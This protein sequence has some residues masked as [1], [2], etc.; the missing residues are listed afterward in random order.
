MVEE[1]YDDAECRGHSDLFFPSDDKP[2]KPAKY[3]IVEA[4]RYCSRCPVLNNCR[5][6][7]QKYPQDYIDI[8]N[9]VVAGCF[10]AEFRR[11]WR[12]SSERGKKGFRGL[13]YGQMKDYEPLTS[14]LNWMWETSANKDND[15]TSWL[16]EC[17]EKVVVPSSIEDKNDDLQS[18]NL[19]LFDSPSEEYDDGNDYYDYYHDGCD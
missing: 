7:A 5:E 19:E 12:L 4:V 2:Q 9:M 16:A 11:A 3:R 1:W 6:Y 14:A 10:S 8:S 18:V 17:A 15:R 13:R